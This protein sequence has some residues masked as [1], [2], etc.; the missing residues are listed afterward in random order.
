MSAAE[1]G[2]KL[3]L[4][5]R[6]HSTHVSRCLAITYPTLLGAIAGVNE[7]GLAVTINQGYATDL[8]R[9]R[10]GLFGTLV[11]QRCLDT[12]ASVEQAV[13]LALATPVPAGA[14]LSMVDAGG[15][16]AV[17]EL[18]GTRRRRRPAVARGEVMATFN[19]YGVVELAEVE[20]PIGAVTAGPWAGID[21]HACNLTRAARLNVLASARAGRAWSDADIEATL[22][23]H[24]GGAGDTLTL[25][26]HD[27]PLSET[28]VSALID[29]VAR[30][31]TVRH[32][33]ACDAAAERF[34]L[35]S[36]ERAAA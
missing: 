16:R 29:P 22:A 9:R 25:C 18:S 19:R 21:V 4:G 1:R 14:M 2:E 28:V 15:A 32:G 23:D 26:R 31:M 27:D 17:V 33:N 35:D 11:L 10:P 7:A 36:P 3:I 13:T 24:D 20:I 6:K 5:A 12:C 8:S 34:A 30:T